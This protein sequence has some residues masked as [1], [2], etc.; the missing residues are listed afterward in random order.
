[1]GCS[2]CSTLL[3]WANA[4]SCGWMGRA[5]A[6]GLGIIMVTEWWEII[7]VTPLLLPLLRPSPNQGAT[8]S[9]LQNWREWFM[10]G[11]ALMFPFSGS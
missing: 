4:H 2:G 5:T 1:M 11:P 3:V 10:F 9:H 8:A 7:V 6:L